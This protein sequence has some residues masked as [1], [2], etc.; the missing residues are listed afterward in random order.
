MSTRRSSDGVELAGA[1]TCRTFRPA[2]GRPIRRPEHVEEVDA[3]EH[4][5]QC[6]DDEAAD[7]EG[8]IPPPPDRPRMSSMLPRSPALHRI[9]TSAVGH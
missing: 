6:D 8:I 9:R 1:L 7:T 4:A 2:S 3:G 5:Q